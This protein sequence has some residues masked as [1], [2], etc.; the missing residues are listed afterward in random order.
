MA[1]GLP[2]EGTSAQHP[3]AGEAARKDVP[4]YG[5]TEKLSEVSQ[6]VSRLGWDSVVV[7]NEE[8]VVFG[9]VGFEK[10]ITCS[11]AVD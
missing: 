8:P 10:H 4:T 9:L 1:A 11:P 2:T 5:L 6:R 3:R 7:V